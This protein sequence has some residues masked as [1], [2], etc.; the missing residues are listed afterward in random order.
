MGMK[1]RETPRWNQELWHV[2]R[3]VT[4]VAKWMGFCMPCLHHSIE[5]ALSKVPG[6]ARAQ[7]IVTGS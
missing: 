6:R 3:S 5:S 1:Q 2:V 7:T 4:T